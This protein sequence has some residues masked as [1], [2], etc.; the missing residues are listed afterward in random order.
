MRTCIGRQAALTH[1]ELFGAVLWVPSTTNTSLTVCGRL[2]RG[3]DQSAHFT[4]V[5]EVSTQVVHVVAATSLIVTLIL[6]AGKMNQLSP[7]LVRS[8]PPQRYRRA[9]A[10]SDLLLLSHCITTSPIG[11]LVST[12]LSRVTALRLAIALVASNA[13]S[14]LIKLF[15]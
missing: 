13:G 6:A 4:F 3:N 12:T 15:G 14:L 2:D 7:R 5:Q 11:T 10:S 8:L 1:L 9:D